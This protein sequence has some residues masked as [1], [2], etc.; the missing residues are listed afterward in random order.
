MTDNPSDKKPRAEEGASAIA[1]DAV[2]GTIIVTGSKNVQV[3]S[4]GI[5]VGSGAVAAE[6]GGV[7]VGGNTTTGEVFIHE[8]PPRVLSQD[9][10]FERIGAAVRSNL[11]QLERN[12]DKARVESSQFFKLTLSFLRAS[13]F[14]SCQLVLVSF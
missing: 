8:G 13:V 9:Q 6:K 2:S 5:A 3:G 4:G 1:Q 10:A 12:I 14:L 11:S 7:F